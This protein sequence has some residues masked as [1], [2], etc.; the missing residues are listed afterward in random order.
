MSTH[1]RDQ[2][3]SVTSPRSY[4]HIAT[5]G[6][7]GSDRQGKERDGDRKGRNREGKERDRKKRETGKER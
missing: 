4:S 7:K 1:I 3:V 6:E 2:R 5:E